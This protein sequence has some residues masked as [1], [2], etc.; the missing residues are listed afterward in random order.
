M[1]FPLNFSRGSH[2]KMNTAPDLNSQFSIQFFDD[3][4][5]AALNPSSGRKDDAEAA[6]L[7]F[8]EHPDSL[9][10]IDE[11][12]K[13]SSRTQSKFIAMQILEEN[14]K[15]RW[16]L[17]TESARANVRQYVFSFVMSGTFATSDIVLHKLNTILVEIAKKDWPQRW[18]SFITDLISI[19]Q[20]TSMSVASNTLCILKEMNEQI[21]RMEHEVTTARKRCLQATLREEYFKIFR[22]ISTILEYS[23]TQEL[24]EDLLNSCFYA[25]CSFCSSMPLE[26]VFSTRMVEC[27]ITHLNSQH[28][29]AA[30]DCLTE[31]VDLDLPN[32]GLSLSQSMPDVEQKIVLIHNELTTF[33]RMYLNKF[34][35]GA[36]LSTSYRKLP[37]E[38]KTF[39]KKYASAFA[40]LFSGWFSVL[41]P[42][43]V[44]NSL[45]L[46]VH[47][48]RIDDKLLFSIVF[49]TWC[50]LI[51]DMH[52]EYPLR[53]YISRTLQRE[54][55]VPT[56]KSMLP[57]FVHNM[58]RPD[59]VF[60]RINDLGEIIKDRKV[61][62]AETELYKKMKENLFCLSFIIEK[63]VKDYLEISLNKYI[64]KD[65]IITCQEFNQ[66]CWTVGAL[67]GAFN[68]KEEREFFIA[69][70]KTLLS[71]C[72]IRNLREEK[73]VVASNIMFIIGQYNRFLKH[74]TEFLAVV[75]RKLFE[76]M[77]ETY[78][79][80]KEMACDNFF[81]ICESCPTHFYTH[82]DGEV[83]FDQVI[84]E[85]DALRQNLDFQL[86]RVVLEG[87]LIVIQ[88]GP[89]KDAASASKIY[90]ALTNT[91]LLSPN[92]G[93]RTAEMV[94]TPQQLKMLVHLVDSYTLG[95][96]IIPQV[97]LQLVDL[98]PFF[99]MFANLNPKIEPGQLVDLEPLKPSGILR[100]S[101]SKLFIAAIEAYQSLPTLGTLLERISQEIL[102]GFAG[103]ATLFDL[104][105]AI[106]RAE[107]NESNR[108]F[109]L[110]HF[111]SLMLEPSLIYLNRAD[112]FPDAASSFISLLSEMAHAHVPTTWHLLFNSSASKELMNGLFLSLTSLWEVSTK[113]IS[114]VRFL[115]KQA[116]SSNFLQLF[117]SYYFVALENLLGLVFDRDMRKTYDQQ[118]EFL[119][120]MIFYIK[121]VVPSDGSPSR[122]VVPSITDENVKEFINELFI[123]NFRNVTLKSIELFIAGLFGI[124][125]IEAFK[126]HLD[127]FNIK[128]NEYGDDSD[129]PDEEIILKE[130]IAKK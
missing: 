62:T 3:V 118:V 16:F 109:R 64:K 36:E 81:R 92:S 79:G 46:F 107:T 113:S 112:E 37:E 2:P 67:A 91:E 116:F 25:F 54:I 32:S 29:V 70:V 35:A 45:D 86:Q 127:D 12:M 77:D 83:I 71:I 26:F 22:F 33:F 6:L 68:E 106:I 100:K 61:E 80:I 89:R 60:I 1:S 17:L 66:L 97:V 84:G 42:E 43:R 123:K 115:F 119:Y 13:N 65:T 4:V 52:N 101:L 120:E 27:I 103:E 69:I 49:P 121:P 15:S 124:R 41:G 20:S 63:Y 24:E 19:A 94:G 57:I 28:S 53:V 82:Q 98:S 88:K 10:K 99:A 111:M 104:A 117:Y 105:G 50:K 75:L 126:E 30:L 40:S 95:L 8:K 110:M 9:I 108:S 72:E 128:I 5:E 96:R 59:E 102:T 39:L 114:V 125:N 76:F 38:E 87:L 58:P 18:L 14:V 73:A 48:S 55:F 74:N 122:H 56:L 51:S 47:L 11:I 85:L 78:E 21:F 23:E 34:T 7:K 90:S 44:S 93:M 31:I 129:I 130:R